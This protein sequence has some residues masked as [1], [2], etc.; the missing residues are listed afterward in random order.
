MAF[1]FFLSSMD[2][3]VGPCE[4]RLDDKLRN[5]LNFMYFALVNKSKRF[6]RFCEV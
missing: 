6:Y 5:E 2:I 4:F 1:F 3:L